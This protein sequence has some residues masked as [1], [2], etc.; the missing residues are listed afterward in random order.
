MGKTVLRISGMH[1]GSCVTLVR[2]ALQEAGAKE[3]SLKLN[4]KGLSEA[5]FL[6]DTPRAKLAAAVE[7][8]G[9]GVR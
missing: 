7:R 3:I 8:E 2:E 9:Y 1:C 4:E 5:S 6:S